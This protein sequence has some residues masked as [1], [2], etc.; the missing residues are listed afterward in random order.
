[1]AKDATS[2]AV[3]EKLVGNIFT[4]PNF[5]LS[6]IVLLI[7]FFLSHL[8]SSEGG[9]GFG[10]FLGTFLYKYEVSV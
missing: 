10:W 2:E 7:I 5:Y 3:T 4:M 1:M 9:L 8:L 6:F